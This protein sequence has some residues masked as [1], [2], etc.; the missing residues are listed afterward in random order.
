MMQQHYLT[1]CWG[2]RDLYDALGPGFHSVEVH[3]GDTEESVFV[4]IVTFRFKTGGKREISDS[5][6]K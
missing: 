3:K 1:L 6:N 2:T 4:T 5:K